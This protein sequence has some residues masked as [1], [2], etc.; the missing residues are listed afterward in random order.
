MTYTE[1]RARLWLEENVER[2]EASPRSARGSTER[3]IIMLSLPA[4]A[5]VEDTIRGW[6]PL[7]SAGDTIV[8]CGDTL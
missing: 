4:G 8:D 1:L 3:R 6:I 2:A 5:T 7:C